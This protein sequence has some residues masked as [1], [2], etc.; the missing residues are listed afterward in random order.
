MPLEALAALALKEGVKYGGNWLSKKF[1]GKNQAQNTQ[2]PQYS[3]EDLAA[4]GQ[5]RDIG[6]QGIQDPYA[7]F[8]P[9]AQNARQQFS[10][11]TMPGIVERFGGL[12]ATRSSGY[13]GALAGAG[14][15]LESNLAAQQAQ[16]G[17]QNRNSMMNLMQ[18]GL[19]PQENMYRPESASAMQNMITK[20]GGQ[21]INAL[22]AFG[23]KFLQDRSD[24]H[25]EQ[26]AMAAWKEAQAAANAKNDAENG[27]TTVYP[28]WDPNQQNAPMWQSMPSFGQNV[29]IGPKWQAPQQEP[30]F[31]GMP[32][33]GQNLGGY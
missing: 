25:K 21:G 32:W 15:N 13:Q 29:P 20:L 11:Q 23:G 19:R 18:L 4:M 5:A 27:N 1:G 31:S 28:K 16:Y 6:L 9:I 7:G 12:G 30:M 33:F 10:S 22:S 3:P 14:R 8:E 2:L 24:R 17:I 26:R